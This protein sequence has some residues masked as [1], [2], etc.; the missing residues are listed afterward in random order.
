MRMKMQ[1]ISG[2]ENHMNQ[3]V[4][5]ENVKFLFRDTE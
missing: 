2:V 5:Q 4:E 1:D 3:S